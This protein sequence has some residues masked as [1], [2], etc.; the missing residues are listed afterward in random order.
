MR[1]LATVLPFGFDF[2]PARFMSA[3]AAMGVRVAQFYRNVEKPPTAAEAVRLVR[4]L[5]CEFDSIHAVFGAHID[6]S[7]PDPEHRAE[8]LRIYADEARLSLDLGVRMLVVHPAAPFKEPRQLS[9]ASAD[10]IESHRW[11]AFEDFARR[12]A[13][14]GEKMGVVYLIENLTRAFPMGFHAGELARRVLAV[15]SPALRMCFDTGHAHNCGDVVSALRASAPAIAYLHV[16]D[17]DGK[18]DDHRMPGDG[19]IAW[20]AFAAALNELR[21]NVPCM[22]EVFYE[23][24]RVEA[25]ANAGLGPRLHAACAVD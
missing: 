22:F 7:S 17:N 16:H 10:A 4:G 11:P 15:G 2:D 18:L 6:P 14:Q 5:H 12:L 1:R 25:L 3:Y 24:A 13:E 9:E 19:T 20:S 21:L 23:E 8:C